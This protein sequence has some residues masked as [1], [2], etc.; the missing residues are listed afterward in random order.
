VKGRAITQ[1]VS[2]WFPTA[3]TRVRARARSC[4]ICGGKSGIG[5]AF[6]WVLWF[7][8]PI[9]FSP[10]SP[11]SQSP[12]ADTI[13]QLGADLPSGPSLDSTPELWELKKFSD[14]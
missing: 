2:R 5:T 14:L 11:S 12:G 9:L 3:A 4:G 6:L 8:L 10:N 1:A 7:P 13:G